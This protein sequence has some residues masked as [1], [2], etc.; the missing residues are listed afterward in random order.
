MKVSFERK[1]KARQTND[2]YRYTLVESNKRVDKETEQEDRQTD[3][4]QEKQ[5]YNQTGK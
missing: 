1:T 4:K 5:I 3:E 2:K